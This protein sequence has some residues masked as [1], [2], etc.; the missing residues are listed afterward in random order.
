MKRAF[1]LVEV[2]VVFAIMGVLM[3]LLLP[4]L[5]SARHYS[6]RATCLGN[7][8]QV[9]IGTRLYT[10]DCD[11]RLPAALDPW[12]R[13]LVGYYPYPPEIPSVVSLLVPYTRSRSVFACPVDQG[14]HLSSDFDVESFFVL[15]GSSFQFPNLPS[16]RLL[17]SIESHAS[18]RYANDYSGFWHV[19]VSPDFNAQRWSLLFL[20]GH[21]RFGPHPGA[22]T[23]V[24]E[25]Q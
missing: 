25:I 22:G 4:V 24:S 8:R 21:V 18:T 13:Y 3:A 14:S 1:T 7:L 16:G 23:S 12:S 9:G 17:A 10:D 2:M 20:D 11:D 15:L 19:P 6:K 5:A